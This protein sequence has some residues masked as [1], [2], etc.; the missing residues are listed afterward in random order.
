MPADSALWPSTPH[1]AC[2]SNI[3]EKN[4]PPF[5]LSFLA[6]PRRH[7]HALLPGQESPFNGTEC[8]QTLLLCPPRNRSPRYSYG[9]PPPSTCCRGPAAASKTCQWSSSG[10]HQHAGATGHLDRQTTLGVSSPFQPRRRW[11]ERDTPLSPRHYLC[12]PLV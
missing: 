12:L 10:H 9:R 11:P 7:E 1:F 8:S 2:Y 5:P 4:V 6:T 3:E